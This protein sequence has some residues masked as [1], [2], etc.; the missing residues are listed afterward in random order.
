MT[1]AS[2]RD[3][4]LVTVSYRGDLELARALCRS[5]DDFLDPEI[6][7]ILVVSR[8]DADLFAPLCSERR[9]IVLVEDVLPAGYHRIPAP[10][11]IRIGPFRRRVRELWKAPSGLARG[12]IIQQIV[13]L[14]AP[15]FCDRQTI[16]FADSDI[17]LLGDLPAS[18]LLIG[19][20]TRLYRVPGATTD[21]ADHLRWHR[22]AARLLGLTETGYLGSDYIG[23]LI[24]WRTDALHRLQERLQ[25][26]SGRRWDTVIA[27]QSAFS[28]YILYGAF[29][30]HV[31][32]EDASGH[33]FTEEDLVHA[34]WF[35]DLATP[36]G[37]AAFRSGMKPQHV[38]VAIQSTEGFTLDGRRALIEGV[39]AE[40]HRA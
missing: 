39:R 37:I 2:G 35:Y 8:A 21:S 5:V 19:N 14:A 34:G 10:Q 18:R 7:H 13:K 4:S 31:L 15:T 22:S 33:A 3:V 36:E 24:S 9:R 1:T 20:R 6:E 28:E 40:T 29:V 38:A 11:Q 30:E 27:R 16:V 25:E 12:W 17:E 32:G 26:V 23:N